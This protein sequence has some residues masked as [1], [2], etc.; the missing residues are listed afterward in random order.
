MSLVGLI[1][2]SSQQSKY[3]EDINKAIG[4]CVNYLTTLPNSTISYAASDVALWEHSDGA[5]LVEEEPKSIVGGHYFL[6]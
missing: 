2:A 1:V 4:R 3:S 5:H 6:S